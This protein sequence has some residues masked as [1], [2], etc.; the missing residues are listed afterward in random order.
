MAGKCFSKECMSE[1]ETSPT[2]I[3]TVA[4][5]ENGPVRRK[6]KA[7][8]VWLVFFGGEWV[9]ISSFKRQV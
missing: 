7:F 8:L 3:S 9:I 2:K 6:K 1:D 5:S 4:F